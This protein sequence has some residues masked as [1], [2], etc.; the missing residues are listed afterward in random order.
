M[1]NQHNLNKIGEGFAEL[2]SLPQDMVVGATLFNMVGNR[3]LIIENFKGISF[4][5][6]EEVQI[7]GNGV[8]Y[9]ITGE[10]L[11]IEYFSLEDM[12]ISGKIE[13]VRVIDGV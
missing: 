12:K 1:S 7:R 11:L 2:F 6:K 10:G 4:Y 13:A 3:I 9:S 5:T 8:I